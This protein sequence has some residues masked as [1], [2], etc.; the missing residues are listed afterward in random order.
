MNTKLKEAIKAAGMLNVEFARALGANKSQ[1][2]R[3]VSGQHTPTRL[4]RQ[5]INRV[6]KCEVYDV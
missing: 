3:W 5:Q 2:T 6:L 1:I 4:R